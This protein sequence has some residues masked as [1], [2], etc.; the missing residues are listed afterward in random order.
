MIE[1]IL[2]TN[3][4]NNGHPLTPSHT[5]PAAPPNSIQSWIHFEDAIRYEPGDLKLTSSEL[6]CYPE[7]TKKLRRL[8]DFPLVK[9]DYWLD[10]KFHDHTS[11]GHYDDFFKLCFD[12]F[13][14]K[15][16]NQDT[17][18]THWITRL[19]SRPSTPIIDAYQLDEQGYIKQC[20]INGLPWH[21]STQSAYTGHPAQYLDL[22]ELFSIDRQ[23]SI[24]V[25]DAILGS[26]LLGLIVR[27]SKKDH[28]GPLFWYNLQTRRQG[29]I[30]D[31]VRY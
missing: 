7:L 1:D 16:I 29:N 20:V 8:P 21:L 3:G 25:E 14:K 26:P 5:N 30:A 11:R 22:H 24:Q 17:Q 28:K 15:L 10:L 2:T 19:R 13:K 6:I 27:D 4:A 9:Q 31:A 23:L 12:L 18:V